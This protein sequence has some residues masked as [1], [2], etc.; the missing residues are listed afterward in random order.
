[1]RALAAI[2]S[3]LGSPRRPPSIPARDTGSKQISSEMTSR[4]YTLPRDF[5]PSGSPSSFRLRPTDRQPSPDRMSDE[6]RNSAY[7]ANLSAWARHAAA[8]NGFGEPST[9]Q[10]ERRKTMQ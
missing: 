6:I 9:A 3:S 8:A 7:H 5:A 2:A 1:M 10:P 4:G